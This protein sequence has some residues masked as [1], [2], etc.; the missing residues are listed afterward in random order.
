MQTTNTTTTSVQ[1]KLV[2]AAQVLS[3]QKMIQYQSLGA[4]TATTP[5]SKQ[6]DAKAKVR[7]NVEPRLTIMRNAV[8]TV[9]NGANTT[10]VAGRFGIPART[11]RRYVANAKRRHGDPHSSKKLDKNN[12][13]RKKVI[14]N[15]LKLSITK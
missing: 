14:E 11:L 15:R 8:Q 2:H 6:V 12:K 13:V 7:W 3:Q 1:Q 10:E 4:P 5:Q 9:L